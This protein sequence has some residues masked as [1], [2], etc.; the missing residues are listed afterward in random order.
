MEEATVHGVPQSP[1]QLHVHFGV[2]EYP[3]LI[4][5]LFPCYILKFYRIGMY[6]F[7]ILVAPD[8]FFV[9]IF[10]VVVI[11]FVFYFFSPMFM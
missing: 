9:L 7:L 6:Y 3:G 5:I 4:R 11:F 2:D 8:E 1:A 10:L